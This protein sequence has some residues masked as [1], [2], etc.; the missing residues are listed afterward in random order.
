MFSGA[1]LSTEV[2][3]MSLEFAKVCSAGK[4]WVTILGQLFGMIQ[5]GGF[6]SNISRSEMISTH[7][8]Q[9]ESN[10]DFIYIDCLYFKLWTS[11]F[12]SEK[13]PNKH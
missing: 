2:F 4:S 10:G 7:L 11:L 8:S 9:C 13:Q 12:K 3:V 5:N 6:P 1:Q